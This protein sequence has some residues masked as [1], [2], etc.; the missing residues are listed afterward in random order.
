MTSNRWQPVPVPKDWRYDPR[1]LKKFL[2]EHR[3]TGE[4]AGELLGVDSR[5]I[6]RWT[7]GESAMPYSAWYCLVHKSS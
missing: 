3:L 5:T 2:S 7:G 1:D 6:R 4:A